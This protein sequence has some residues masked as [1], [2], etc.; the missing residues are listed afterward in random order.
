MKNLITFVIFSLVLTSTSVLADTVGWNFPTTNTAG[1]FDSGASLNFSISAITLG[2]V[3]GTVATP[4]T[5]TSASSGYTGSSAEGNIGNATKT[6]ALSTST[7]SYFQFTLTPTANSA[8]T[9]SDFD[10]GIRSTGT[11]AQAYSLQA[12]SSSIALTPLTTGSVLANSSWS[13]KDNSFTGMTFGAGESV[14]LRLYVYGGAGSPG[15]NTINTRLDDITLVASAAAVSAV[16]EPST[17]ALVGGAV[18]LTGAMLHRRRR[19]TKIAKS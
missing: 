18:A 12:F 19:M 3:L 6:G 9:I 8:I 5:T 10:F 16:P 4:V 17:Y 14:T 13:Y 15:N 1:T 11:G 7:S 2:N